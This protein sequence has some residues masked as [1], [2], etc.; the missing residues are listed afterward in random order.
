MLGENCGFRGLG[1][2]YD[3]PSS[4]IE[5]I[6]KPK[7]PSTFQIRTQELYSIVEKAS[8][9]IGQMHSCF[10]CHKKFE[11]RNDHFYHLAL[12]NDIAQGLGRVFALSRHMKARREIRELFLR[13]TQTMADN[14]MM[15]ATQWLCDV[16][17]VGT[18]ETLPA[19][20]KVAELRIQAGL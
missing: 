9:Q 12:A 14:A 16:C 11:L 17:L 15:V 19:I 18:P 6:K 20:K 2:R 7:R 13:L 10:L 3:M 5:E 1:Q 8:E 4:K